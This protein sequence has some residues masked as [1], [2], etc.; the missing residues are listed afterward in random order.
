MKSITEIDALCNTMNIETT[1]FQPALSE[2]LNEREDACMEV[3][4]VL[5]NDSL[6]TKTIL[7]ALHQLRRSLFLHASKLNSTEAVEKILQSVISRFFESADPMAVKNVHDAISLCA[8]LCYMDFVRRAK[9][10]QLSQVHWNQLIATIPSTYDPKALVYFVELVNAFN[11]YAKECFDID[12]VKVTTSTF[13]VSAR[14]D[15]NVLEALFKY[16][17][18]YLDQKNRH[19]LLLFSSIFTFNEDMLDSNLMLERC[20][21]FK[22]DELGLFLNTVFQQRE[23]FPDEAMDV[24]CCMARMDFNV[25][26]EYGEILLSFIE[27]LLS[28]S[29]LWACRYMS[30]LF[31][32]YFYSQQHSIRQWVS[33]ARNASMLL[34]FSIAHL[35]PSSHCTH[36]ILQVWSDISFFC[37]IDQTPLIH[38]YLSM[39][40]EHGEEDE[41]VFCAEER[42]ETEMGCLAK[43]IRT[44]EPTLLESILRITPNGD[45]QQMW[46]LMVLAAVWDVHE[47]SELCCRAGS[48][49]GALTDY[50]TTI[51]Q[52]PISSASPSLF[53]QAAFLSLM[54]AFYSQY[55]K[56]RDIRSLP[57]AFPKISDLELFLFGK[58]L[59]LLEF[60]HHPLLIERALSLL[61][62]V[63]MLQ[64]SDCFKIDERFMSKMISLRNRLFLNVSKKIRIDFY[65]TFT[66]WMELSQLKQ[67]LQVVKETKPDERGMADMRGILLGVTL[68]S[69]K[70]KI[71]LVFE[72]AISHFFFP[73]LISSSSVKLLCDLIRA[74]PPNENSFVLF[75]IAVD[76]F[77][78]FLTLS[79]N[80]EKE[81][82]KSVR[83]FLALWSTVF[84]TM[85]LNEGEK[86]VVLYAVQKYERNTYEESLRLLFFILPH[87]DRR[88]KDIAS[89]FYKAL[90]S[91]VCLDKSLVFAQCSGEVSLVLDSLASGFHQHTD[92]NHSTLCEESICKIAK[93]LS[94]TSN[95]TILLQVLELL[96]ILREQLISIMEKN[97]KMWCR[98][99]KTLYLVWALSPEMRLEQQIADVTI[100][101]WF[102]DMALFVRS[103]TSFFEMMVSFSC[104]TND[105]MLSWKFTK[106]PELSLLLDVLT[107]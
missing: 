81:R 18:K 107:L 10:N 84:S 93:R 96:P 26:G 12:G 67:L 14:F 90:L 59:T 30:C 73:P 40:M 56:N 6:Y 20:R 66:R 106:R 82:Q 89:L 105:T 39:R 44:S 100:R 46:L 35:V 33:N 99:S 102:E 5:L 86:T 58:I 25:R 87:V 54:E 2:L 28:V 55:L 31:S 32:R 65:A 64:K 15:S 80:T 76:F 29:G 16:A 62:Y 91:Y 48:M 52:L 95:P 57:S 36:Y 79:C 53:I 27:P 78:S 17:M 38:A 61:K 7:L 9:K 74:C 97:D 4:M 72:C 42:F 45:R 63:C 69:S 98:K 94:K 103:K 34:A 3:A 104:N 50:L 88:R 92:D 13:V 60:M 49:N 43:I 23:L 11:I 68:W 19:T 41:N 47:K 22:E 1:Y 85:F 24:L 77:R 101:R 71:Q 8:T 75:H 37:A 21:F 70:K 51:I 83:L